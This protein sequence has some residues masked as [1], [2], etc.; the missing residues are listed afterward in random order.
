MTTIDYTRFRVRGYTRAEWESSNDILLEREIGVVLPDP[1]VADDHAYRCKL[2]LGDNV[3]WNDKDYVVLGLGGI[4]LSTLVDGATLQWDATNK[5]WKT[6]ASGGYGTIGCTFDGGGAALAAGAFCDVVIPYNC[7]INAAT[8]LADQIGSLVVSV[9]SDIY[10]TYPP[11][12]GDNIAASAPPTLS[13][14]IKSR[15]TTLTGWTTALT[16]GSTIR[17]RVTSCSLIAR[18]TLTLEVTKT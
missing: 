4:D 13:S 17:F 3:P 18:A 10:G 6:G 12:S 14:A 2:G 7:T 11:T 1:T 16:K 5:R 8:L 9:W 15:D